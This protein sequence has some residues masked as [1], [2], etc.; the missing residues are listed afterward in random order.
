VRESVPGAAVGMVI[1]LLLLARN[2]ADRD[3]RRS[4]TFRQ[5]CPLPK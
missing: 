5:Q 1:A 2:L 3:S 4:R